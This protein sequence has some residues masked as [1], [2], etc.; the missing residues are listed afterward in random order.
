MSQDKYFQ[1]VSTDLSVEETQEVRV[2]LGVH[3]T[4]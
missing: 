1:G 3:V 2:R 4:P